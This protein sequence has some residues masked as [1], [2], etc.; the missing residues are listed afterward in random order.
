MQHNVTIHNVGEMNNSRVIVI[1][2]TIKQNMHRKTAYFKN[3]KLF[4]TGLLHQMVTV[5][6]LHMRLFGIN[7]PYN[8]ITRS[9]YRRE[10]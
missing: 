2:M 1:I 7:K 3:Y 10:G 8:F 9:S 4:C 5:Y 6:P